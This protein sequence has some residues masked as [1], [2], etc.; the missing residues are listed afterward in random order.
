MDGDTLE[1]KNMNRQL[2]T[3][4]DIGKNKAE[5]LA[6]RYGCRVVPKWYAQGVYTYRPT[7]WLICCADNH[8]T[9]L[10]V[11]DDCDSMGCQAIIAANERTSS[12]A[13]VYRRQWRDSKRDPRVYYPE[14]ITDKS[15]DPRRASIG[16]TGEAQKET[17]QLVTANALAAGLAGHLLTV[18]SLEAKKMKPEAIQFFEYRINKNMTSVESTRVGQE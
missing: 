14:I 8:P 5:V 4:A 17:P 10:A 7:D 3:N 1:K 18:W 11:L 6:A 9:R 13:Y 12:E 2:F 16:C 15:G